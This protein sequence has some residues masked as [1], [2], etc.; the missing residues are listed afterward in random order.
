M[1]TKMLLGKVLHNTPLLLLLVIINNYT[2]IE[3]Q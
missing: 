2:Q 3:S 1:R